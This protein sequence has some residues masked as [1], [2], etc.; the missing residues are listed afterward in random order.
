MNKKFIN[1]NT[2]M[3]L[4]INKTRKLKIVKSLKIS[5]DNIQ[6]YKKVYNEDFLKILD[7]LE[8]IMMRQGEPFRS[9]AYHK[10]SETIMTITDDITDIKQLAKYR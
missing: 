4:S 9:R 6:M 5:L 7:E 1:N 10:A 2:N 8:D 3:M